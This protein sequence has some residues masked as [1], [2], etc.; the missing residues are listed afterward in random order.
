LFENT[1]I[2]F[3]F[4]LL[5]C[6]FAEQI[7]YNH[8]IYMMKRVITLV[9]L[10]CMIFT[11]KSEGLTLKELTGGFYSA[12]GISGVTP[13]LDGESYSQLSR[14]GKQ[15]IRHSFKTGEETEVLF[16]VNNIRNRIRL[17]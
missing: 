8:N 3:A 11:A 9:L 4:S 16:D 14:D 15:I 17:D 5:I 1:Y 13:L 2:Y 12:R 10:L 7:E 6:T